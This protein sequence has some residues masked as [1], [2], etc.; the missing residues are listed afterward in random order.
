MLLSL[1][2]D[3]LMLVGD[4]AGFNGITHA[5]VSGRCAGE[6]AAE[7]VQEGDV[8]E[9]KLQRYEDRCRQIGLHL[10]IGSWDKLL[11]LQQ[12]SDEAIEAVLPEMLAKNQVEYRDLLPI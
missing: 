6:V 11:N 8:R 12:L 3:G 10:T 2:E 7:A 9:R 5:I 4:S 1:V